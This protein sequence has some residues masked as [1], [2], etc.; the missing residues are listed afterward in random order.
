MNVQK[1]NGVSIY[2]L[3]SGPALPEWLG[4]RARRN[5]SKKDEAIRRRIELIQDFQMPASSSKLVRSF[6]GRYII[7]AGTYPPRIRCYDVHELTMKFER[8]VNAEIVDIVMLGEDYGKLALLQEDRTISFHAHYGAHESIRIPTFG[9][10]MAYEP[11]T[12]ELLVAAKG[13]RIFRVD[14]EEGRFCEPWSYDAS[15]STSSTSTLSDNESATCIAVNPSYP[16]ACVGCG[17]GIVRFWDNRAPDTLGPLLRLD[18]QSATAGYGYAVVDEMAHRNIHEVSAVTFD[19]TGM[20]MA[21]GTAGGLVALYDVRSSRPLLVQEHKHGL[22]INTVKFHTGSG[23]LMSSDEKLLKIWRYKPSGDV[24]TT[25]NT[26]DNSDVGGQN[27]KSSALGSVLVNIESSGKIAHFIVAGDESDPQGEKS[28]VLLMATDQPKME[29]YY[30]PAVGVAPKWCSFLESIT[31]ELAERDLSRAGESGDPLQAGEEAV[32]ENYKFVSRDELNQLGIA[33]LIGTPLLRGY[34]HGFFMD[35]NLY[36]RAKSVA[37][38]FEYEEYRKK[39]VKERLE[40][41]RASRIATKTDAKTKVAVNPDLAERL[42]TKAGAR[43]KAGRAAGQ[44]L[45]DERFGNL[46]TNPDYHIDEEDE[47]FKLRNPSGVA[48][49]RRKKDNLDSDDDDEDDQDDDEASGKVVGAVGSG[50]AERAVLEVEDDD[51]DDNN[52]DDAS[53]DSDSEEDGF[54]GARVRGEAYE[55]LKKVQGS[56]SKHKKDSNQQKVPR[57]RKVVMKEAE[58][59]AMNLALGKD[60][61]STTPQVSETVNVKELPLS[62]RLALSAEQNFDSEVRL[63]G[64]SKEVSYV[65]KDAKRRAELRGGDD[66]DRR[67][68]RRGAKGLR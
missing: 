55:E 23:M 49:V 45:S 29:S 52:D 63:K 30:V 64:G 41:K 46:F 53:S 57:T 6:D 65:P 22:P 33:H 28:G 21:A 1:R 35:I 18:V 19:S 34:M 17:D 68:K 32:Y 47:N 59:N 66:Y 3:S 11:S 5:L 48:A 16:V 51:E 36:H 2:C 24:S 8:Y 31:E 9:R 39:K 61:T 54:R 60:T 43:T 4:D 62:T 13:S 7:A 12:C 15:S 58:G 50:Q 37:N 10:A 38:P 27:T 25:K 67:R 44:V 42:Q 14:L 26:F 56:R 40:A 20:Y